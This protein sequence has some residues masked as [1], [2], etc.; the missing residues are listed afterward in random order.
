VAKVARIRPI[1]DVKCRF[2]LQVLQSGESA[3]NELDELR[4]TT[5]TP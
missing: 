5:W 3:S 1:R 4:E 2:I